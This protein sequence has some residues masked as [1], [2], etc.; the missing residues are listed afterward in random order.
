MLVPVLVARET[1]LLDQERYDAVGTSVGVD[2]AM[3]EQ[4]EK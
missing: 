1:G 4:P 3:L 2:A